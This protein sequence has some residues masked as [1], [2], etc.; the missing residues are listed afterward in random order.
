MFTTDTLRVLLTQQHETNLQ[1][2]LLEDAARCGY[3]TPEDYQELHRLRSL[4]A[5]LQYTIAQE[6]LAQSN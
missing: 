3:L 5:E 4:A 1:I 6:R 2:R